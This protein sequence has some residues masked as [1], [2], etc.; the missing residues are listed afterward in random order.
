MYKNLF[1]LFFIIIQSFSAIAQENEYTPSTRI[2]SAYMGSI[3]YPGFKLGV[4]RPYKV[5]QVNE[6]HPKRTKTIY[7]ERLF[8]F[9]FGMYYHQT[10]HTNFLI[11]IEWVTRRQYSKGLFLQNNFGIGLSRTF[12]DR[13][14]Y[15]VSDDGR[16]S[17]VPMAGNFYGLLSMGGSIGY[18]FN[19]K[20]NKRFSVFL[21]PDLILMTPYN[22]FILPR[23]TIE[24]GVSYNIKNFW[25]A[26][27]QRIYKERGQKK[28]ETN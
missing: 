12:L 25:V 17:K 27:P 1:L 18:N 26:N 5:I 23:V 15:K 14:T 21:K 3:I 8:S 22:R 10:Y 11:Q 19:I 28:V 7:K 9:N 24:L 20:N 2:R 6:V 16:V 13:A 4:E